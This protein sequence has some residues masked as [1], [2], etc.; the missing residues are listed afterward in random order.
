LFV[1][2]ARQ[3]FHVP[4][5]L[6]PFV[7]GSTMVAIAI[8]AWAIIAPAHLANEPEFASAP[9]LDVTSI[10]SVAYAE[11]DPV[12]SEDHIMVRA[13]DST[14]SVEAREIAAFYVSYRLP[15]QGS[16]APTA[17]RLAIVTAGAAS[18]YAHLTFVT[19]PSGH[20]QAAV[21]TID[22]LSALAWSPDGRRLAASHTTAGDDSLHGQ[23]DVSE[24]DTGS[25]EAT[26][27]AHFDDVFAASPVGYSQ[28]GTRLFIVVIDQAGS[29]LWAAQNG[30]LT[31]GP[32]LSAGR[33]LEWRLSPDG[34]RL[35]YVDVL[36]SGGGP[37]SDDRSYAGRTLLIA[38]GAIAD[39]SQAGDQRAPAWQPGSLIPVFGGPGGSVQLEGA[40]APGTFV[41]P[42]AWSPDGTMV[43]ATVYAASA[44]G[45]PGTASTQLVIGDHRV[46]LAANDSA[47]FLGWVAN[48]GG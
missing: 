48:Q 18:A 17:D 26:T 27:A 37:A 30:K 31:K 20:Q 29:T 35:A 14:D 22:Y 2:G 16:A 5:H 32:M 13:A 6:P 40:A 24:F 11:L 21:A 25:G 28:D 8:I 38:T 12:T 15:V 36:P 41:T 34:S 4:E 9:P 33:T 43:V 3:G 45:G 7:V 23:V 10:H 19:V 44:D 46:P 47:R 42:G 1:P 39:I